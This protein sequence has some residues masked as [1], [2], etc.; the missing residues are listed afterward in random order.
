MNLF[1]QKVLL[2][3]LYLFSFRGRTDAFMGHA[4]PDASRCC[5]GLA[6]VERLGRQA[7]RFETV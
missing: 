4:R 1:F 5:P 6:G 3:R 2:I 7:G